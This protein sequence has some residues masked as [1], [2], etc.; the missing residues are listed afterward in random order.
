MLD[1]K[2]HQ[3]Y[4]HLFLKGLLLKQLIFLGRW[5]DEKVGRRVVLIFI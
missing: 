2:A 4:A 5:E 3:R 1:F